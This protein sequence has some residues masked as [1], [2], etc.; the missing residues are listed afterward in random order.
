M[1]RHSA[2][3]VSVEPSNKHHNMFCFDRIV[4]VATLLQCRGVCSV[5]TLLPQNIKK[6][7]GLMNRSVMWSWWLGEVQP[8]KS[9]KDVIYV[10]SRYNHVQRLSQYGYFHILNNIMLVCFKNSRALRFV[11]IIQER[12]HWIYSRLVTHRLKCFK[13]FTIDLLVIMSEK[14]GT[15]CCN[16][17]R[18]NHL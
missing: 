1:H 13:H 10:M 8:F 18:H 7:K 9:R 6:E 14:I 4:L 5:G 17:V 11:S 15:F 3:K 16:L 12:E 2:P